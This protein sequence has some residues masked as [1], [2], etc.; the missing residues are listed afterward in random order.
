MGALLA[1]TLAVTEAPS[2]GMAASQTLI[3]LGAAVVFGALFVR[4]ERR[5]PAPLVKLPF[6]GQRNFTGAT[7]VL[8]VLNVALIVAIFFLPL[9]L[10]ELLG[11]S[12]TET[13]A[14]LLPLI[15]SMVVTLPLGGP[16]AER[17]LASF[18][19][20]ARDTVREAVTDA[21]A[22]GLGGAFRF[23]ALVALG[24]LL[25]ALALIRDRPPADE[26]AAEPRGM[27]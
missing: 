11:Y 26:V 25:L 18:A 3:L 24:G 27:T 1:F 7:A 19:H 21:F 15:G 20:S 5:T 4:V 14:L 6:F 16:V 13:G 22:L 12:P 17:T 9:L 2:W 8:F 10:E 23:G